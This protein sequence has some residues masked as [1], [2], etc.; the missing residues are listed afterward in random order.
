FRNLYHQYK[1]QF[2]T[3]HDKSAELFSAEKAQRQA[4]YY[5]QRRNNALLRILEEYNKVED[6][7]DLE[8]NAFDDEKIVRIAHTAPRLSH[9]LKPILDLQRGQSI[10]VDRAHL[11]NL[12]VHETIPELINDDLLTIETNPQDPDNWC[13]RNVPNLV[14]AKFR[15]IKLPA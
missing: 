3:A 8:S 7:L 1:H 12:L 14:T 4:L 13:R 11:V 2:K 6:H 10:D 5:F 9:I 15:P